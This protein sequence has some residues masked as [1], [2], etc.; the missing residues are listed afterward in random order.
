MNFQQ[1]VKSGFQ[2]YGN[3][4]DRAS[5]SEFWWWVL[6]SVLVG[7]V[8]VI[9]DMTVFGVTD[10]KGP[11]D[12][13]TSLALLAPNIAVNARRMHDIDKSG[14][15]MLINLTII[16]IPVFIYWCCQK[17]DAT[18]NRFGPPPVS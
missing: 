18:T 13:V 12:I 10:S 7:V 3:V 16:G 8:A 9:I 2:N 14:W 5:R 4:K 6:F 17:S 11:V 1:A 15:W